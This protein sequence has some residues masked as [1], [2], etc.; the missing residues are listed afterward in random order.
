MNTKFDSH[1][2]DMILPDG[3]EDNMGLYAQSTNFSIPAPP[4]LSTPLVPVSYY[5][6]VD[7]HSLNNAANSYDMYGFSGGDVGTFGL[8]SNVDGG[9]FNEEKTTYSRRTRF[10]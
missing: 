10:Q 4:V 9:S 5:S 6:D 8:H 3:V 7:P 2:D 1:Y